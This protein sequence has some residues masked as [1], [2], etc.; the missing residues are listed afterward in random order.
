MLGV[1]GSSIAA[2]V[3]QTSFDVSGWRSCHFTFD[4]NVRRIAFPPS[5]SSH[6]STS[7]LFRSLVIASWYQS[8][9]KTSSCER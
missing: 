2:T 6:A 5:A 8:R 9:S 7:R 4:F 1:L 3:K